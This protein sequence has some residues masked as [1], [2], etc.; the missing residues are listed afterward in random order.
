MSRVVTLKV[1]DPAAIARVPDLM[2]P[3]EKKK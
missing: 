1:P 3:P 2:Q